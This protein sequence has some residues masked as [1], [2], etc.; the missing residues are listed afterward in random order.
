MLDVFLDSGYEIRR[1]RASGVVEVVLSLR[2]TPR[3]EPKTHERA[4]HAA[5]ASLRP[6][7]DPSAVAVVGAGRRRGTIGAEILNNLRET[8]FSAAHRADQ[9]SATE[10]QGLQAYPRVTD[11]PGPIDLASSPSR[12]RTWMASWTTASPKG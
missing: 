10:M 1:K 8:G 4:T 7:F 6:F 9:P 3:H 12:P 11:V 5:R 2:E